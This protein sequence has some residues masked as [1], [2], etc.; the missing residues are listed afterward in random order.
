[1]NWIEKLNK[2]QLVSSLAKKKIGI[3]GAAKSGVS[4][5]LLAKKVGAVPF[6]SEHKEISKNY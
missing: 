3:L 6:V 2:R 4:A 5:A 1:M